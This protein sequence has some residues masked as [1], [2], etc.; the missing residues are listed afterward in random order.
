MGDVVN[1]DNLLE[2]HVGLDMECL[3]RT[4]L[5][6]Y[7]PRLRWA[8]PARPP[9][10][11]RACQRLAV[12]RETSSRRATS[13]WTRPCSNRRTACRQRCRAALGPRALDAGSLGGALFAMT[14]A[15]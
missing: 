11:Q 13:A 1:I 14:I 2:G 6:V 7:V 9:C 15:S 5:N 8:S 10:S 12:C 3:D 4:Y